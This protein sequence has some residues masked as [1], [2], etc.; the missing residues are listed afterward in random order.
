MTVVT[1][2]TPTEREWG[3]LTFAWRVAKHVGSNAIV[4]AKDLATVGIGAG[5]MSRVDAVRI[6]LSKAQQPVEGASLASD[7]FFPSTTAAAG[8]GGR[9]A[10][11]HPAGRREARRRRDLG[12]RPARLLDGL[13]RAP[14]LPP[15]I[16]PTESDA[17]VDRWLAIRNEVFPSIAMSRAALD[18]QDRRGPEGRVKLLAGDVGFAI[19]TPRDTEDPHAWL[20]VGVLERARGAGNRQRA[21]GGGRG[22]P[23]GARRHDRRAACPSTARRRARGSS[24]GA[25]SG[26]PGARRRWSSTCGTCRRTRRCRPASTSCACRPAAPVPRRLR[27]RGGAVRDVPGEEGVVMPPFEAWLEELAAE[28][29]TVVLGALDGDV[30]AAMAILS[31]RPNTPA[32]SGTG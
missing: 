7:A 25:A 26:R 11:V 4:I 3:D 2:R 13:H 22:A 19:V 6:A 5:Q 16:R 18:L 28:G 23:G 21:V 15:L 12:R 30:L 29:D 14:A 9:R 20:T 32:S 27:A 24:S 8:A 1:Q 31:F 10:L 17:D